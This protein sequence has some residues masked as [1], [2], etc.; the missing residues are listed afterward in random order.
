MNFLQT[1]AA[2][3]QL[4]AKQAWKA[5]AVTPRAKFLKSATEQ[6][7]SL[8]KGETGKW[9]AKQTDDSFKL[10]PHAGTAIMTYEGNKIELLAKD[11]AEAITLFTQ[12]IEAANA[13]EFDATLEAAAKEQRE[14]REAA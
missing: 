4:Q 8:K 6:L 1:V 9:F 3:G 14:N 5:P 7:K 12:M 2:K 13:G 10:W 11:Q